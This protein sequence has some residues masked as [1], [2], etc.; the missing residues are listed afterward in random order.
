MGLQLLVDLNLVNQ[1]AVDDDQNA[2]DDNQNAVDDNQNA[3]YD[4][5][6]H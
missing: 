3:V 2:V 6:G 5:S 4:E 1:N